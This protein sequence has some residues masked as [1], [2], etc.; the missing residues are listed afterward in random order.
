MNIL[1]LCSCLEPGRDGVGDYT[2]RLAGELIRKKHKASIIALND[3]YVKGA[4]IS[5]SQI[6]LSENIP[7]LRLSNDHSWRKHEPL[8]NEFV[9][10]F[11][12]DWLS[13][14]YVCYGFS[15]KGIPFRLAKR[16]N[17]IQKSVSPC[18][19]FHIMFH[20][21]WIGILNNASLKDRIFGLLQKKIIF[22]MISKLKPSLI[23]THTHLYKYKLSRFTV[24]I[25]PLFGNVP[26]Q[27]ITSACKP[28]ILQ[29]AVFGYIHLSS[30]T[31]E[32][33]KS[34]AEFRNVT[35]E[36]VRVVFIGRNGNHLSNWIQRLTEEEINYFVTGEISSAEISMWLQSCNFAVSTTP[37]LLIEKSGTVA[38]FREHQLAV[39]CVADELKSDHYSSSLDLQNIFSYSS[40]NIKIL[41]GDYAKS[42]YNYNL[43]TATNLFIK[44]LNSKT[45]NGK[46]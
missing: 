10:Q 29:V 31:E 9:N 17:K 36:C 13:L 46:S 42:Q 19:N 39:L 14:Q 44:Q 3:N 40:E 11:S 20:E 37:M 45:K 21:I 27:S 1:F 32:F 7:T 22:G 26:L 28:N 6:D 4:P 15:P 23:T 18:V 8:V 25:L 30:I 35:N 2:R 33:I 43:S 16:L 34:L 24:N 12:P 5:Q 38:A 41:H